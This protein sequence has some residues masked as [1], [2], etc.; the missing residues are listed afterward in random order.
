MEPS[1]RASVARLPATPGVYRFRDARGRVLYV[2]RATRLRRRVA[3]YWSDLRDRRHL[4]PMVARI[5]RVEAVACDSE[6][7]AAW[8]E[9]NLLERSLPRWNRTAGGQEVPVYLRLD[10][11]PAAPGL[12]VVHAAVPGAFGPYLGGDRV[13]LAVA[14]L[15]RVLPLS[16][17]GTGRSGS[18]RDMAAKLGVG[19]AD[20]ERLVGALTSVLGRDQAT[21][22]F[23]RDELSTRRDRAAGLLAFELAGRLQAEVEALDWITGPQRVTL[24]SPENLTVHGWAGGVLVRFEIRAGRLDVWSQRACAEAAARRYLDE[25]LRPGPASPAATPN[26]PPRWTR[27]ADWTWTAEPPR[28]WT[29]RQNHGPMLPPRRP[30]LAARRLAGEQPSDHRFDVDPGERVP[31]VGGH[32]PPLRSEEDLVLHGAPDRGVH[33]GDQPPP[34]PG[35]HPRA[36]LGHQPDPAIKARHQA[37]DGRHGAGHLRGGEHGVLIAVE[38]GGVASAGVG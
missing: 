12:T 5:A 25:P 35:L 38:K 27:T 21:V 4:A 2:G 36:A 24:P 18:Q 13:R 34:G 17:T 10:D 20:R 29:P 16:Y 8:L 15:H 32:R 31:A 9:R 7:E 6:H 26:S 37:R 1:P 23:V 14:A 22:A 30:A 28:R 19:P 3:S 11:R 33:L